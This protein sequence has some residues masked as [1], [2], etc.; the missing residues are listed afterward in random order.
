MNDRNSDF[1][2]RN[3]RL[4]WLTSCLKLKELAVV[5][6]NRAMGE[7][8]RVTERGL[9]G[10]VLAQLDDKHENEARVLDE[11]KRQK[12]ALY[13]KGA[14]LN[15]MVESAKDSAGKDKPWKQSFSPE[16]LQ[17][18]IEKNKANTS[19]EDMDETKD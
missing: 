18:Q 2:R 4:K 13:K 16:A 8:L 10:V 6:A 15:K 19:N 17:A 3:A 1:E 9:A 14:S 12:Q 5:N 7:T 11:L